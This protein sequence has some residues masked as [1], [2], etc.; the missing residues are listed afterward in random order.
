M[1]SISIPTIRILIASPHDVQD[2]RQIATHFLNYL[3]EKLAAY[4]HL[5]VSYDDP[6]PATD[7]SP[8]YLPYPSHFDL[9][10]CIWWSQLGSPVPPHLTFM[11]GLP[12]CRSNGVVYESTAVATFEEALSAHESTGKPRLFTL[13]KTTPLNSN[14]QQFDIRLEQRQAVKAFKK[15]WFF[16]EQGESKRHYFQFQHIKEFERCLEQ[17]F[18]PLL[19]QHFFPTQSPLLWTDSPF[20]GLQPFMPEQAPLLFGRD[21]AIADL[22]KRLQAWNFQANTPSFLLIMGPMGCGKSSLVNAGVL[23]LLAKLNIP[24]QIFRP[25]TTLTDIVA[26][27]KAVIANLEPVATSAN[28]SSPTPGKLA[29]ILFID[30]LEE[31]FTLANLSNSVRHEFIQ[32]IDSLA[33]RSLIGVLAALPSE[34]LPCLNEFP[35]MLELMAENRHYLLFP[36]TA[37]ELQQIIAA[38]TQLAGL[39]WENTE[40]FALD[41]VLLQAATTVS[42]DLALLEF[43]LQ[44]LY[45]QR[46]EN[47]CLTQSAYQQI[48]GL[49]GVLAHYAEQFFSQLSE[50]EQQECQELNRLLVTVE[51]AHFITIASH[52]LAKEHL[53]TNEIRTELV[54]KLITAQLLMVN[55][56]AQP[57]V[58]YWPTALLLHWPRLQQWLIEE[59]DLLRVRTRLAAAATAWQSQE[60]AP[61]LLL[62]DSLLLTEAE[63]LLWQWEDTLAEHEKAFLEASLV[64]RQQDLDTRE[65]ISQRRERW[66]RYINIQLSL[67]LLG[68]LVVTIFISWRWWEAHQN[69]QIN[70][71]QKQSAFSRQISTQAVLTAYL[72]NPIN[73][74]FN[75]AL[76][77]AAQAVQFQST[78]E[79]QANLLRVLQSNPQLES[80]WYWSGQT[81]SYLAFSPDGQRLAFANQDNALILWDI[82]KKRPIGEPLLGHTDAI[83]SLVFN[84]FSTQ[85]MSASLDKSI[86]I[87]DLDT[88]LPIGEPWQHDE[89]IRTMA[90]SPD[91]TQL[92]TAGDDKVVR[93]WQLPTRQPL[94]VPLQGHT[95][96]INSI[97]FSPNGKRLA[98]ASTDK[99]VRV[100]ELPPA[101]SAG[102]SL[103]GHTAAVQQV[104]F[105][106]FGTRL[107]S[108]S[109]DNT[110]I[111]WEIDQ[112]TPMG[113]RLP[114]YNTAIQQIAFSPDGKRLAGASKD[115]TVILWDVE[116]KQ[117]IGTPWLGHEAAVHWLAFRPDNEHLISISEDSTL[118]TWNLFPRQRLELTLPRQ[119]TGINSVAFSPNGKWLAGASIDNTLV[120]WDIAQNQTID[121]LP[122]GH[123][124]EITS[125]AFSPNNR[126][127]ASASRD[128]TVRL[129]DM[130]QNVTVEPPLSGHTEVINSIAFSPNGK[131]LASA[132]DDKT[133]IIWDLA[134]RTPV[135]QPLQGHTAAVQSVTFNPSSR[136]LASGGW[137]GNIILWQV[138]DQ[139]QLGLPLQ[140]HQDA[141]YS[142]AFSPN[143]KRLASASRDDTIRIWDI[144][145]RTL[146]GQPLRGHR[147]DVTSIAFGLNGRW[148][149]SGSWDETIQLWDV[150]TQTKLGVL[151]GHSSFISKVTFNSNGQ[152]LASVS[153]D[154]NVKLWEVELSAWLKRAC[155][156][157]GRSLTQTEWQHYFNNEPYQSTCAQYGYK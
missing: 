97:A 38:P 44:V 105:N 1:S 2:E 14:E 149:A 114:G 66:Q 138:K 92:A 125:L 156:I 25:S 21:Q 148:L 51:P 32:L 17:Q 64:Q 50:A 27:L 127:L 10:M 31:L 104:I 83:T 72:P 110:L 154:K 7:T 141:V 122:S 4:L 65:E 86:R 34:F 145:K 12:L 57:V 93:L 11:G 108:T 147:K 33:R 26:G 88:P 60:Q 133:I 91:G 120:I 30:Q 115:N 111:I 131:W 63:D 49:Q 132:S 15:K 69:I 29:G 40:N 150:D 144:Y 78:S 136:W 106:P 68:V 6:I 99:T 101:T 46:H 73:G 102:L 70:Q 100:W 116:R 89:V 61:D 129:W 103:Q 77:L 98:S 90:I 52:P 85:L 74:Y 41:K 76:L 146:I 23:P 87:W 139:T 47:N 128:K 94:G 151:A 19:Q 39:Q 55:E 79:I 123:T 13:F 67:L 37:V 9:V 117:L 107:A 35:N 62:P 142:L 20:R 3:Q 84:P 5:E 36:P 82:N 71:Q 28:S 8:S 96:T 43:T 124:A 135:G 152:W 113:H 22:F 80:Y 16:N 24:Y 137:D 45:E 118:I 134:T 18:Y 157:A 81:I 143:G 140:G 48:G 119:F 75:H 112:E 53:T 153:L 42:N 155:Q 121:S 109:Q 54:N 130:K 58:C 126:W 95:D 59:Q 56:Q